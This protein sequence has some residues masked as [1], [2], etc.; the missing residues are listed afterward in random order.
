MASKQICR[1]TWTDSKPTASVVNSDAAVLVSLDFLLK[2]AGFNVCAYPSAEKL[3]TAQCAGAAQC[4]ILDHG[5]RGPNGLG[6]ARVLRSR[7]LHAPVVLTTGYRCSA[8]EAYARG[9]E[10]VIVTQR[11]DEDVI[12]RLIVMIGEPQGA[13]LR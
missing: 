1:R 5:P 10:P 13:D 6:L 7:G 12:R 8:F 3:L 4:F 11:V 9:L 2:T